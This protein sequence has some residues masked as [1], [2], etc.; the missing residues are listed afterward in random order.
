MMDLEPTPVIIL[1]VV[2]LLV[3]VSA[4]ADGRRLSFGVVGIIVGAAIVW[5]GIRLRVARRRND[6]R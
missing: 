6:H 2:F 1:G 3:G 5:Y 4:A